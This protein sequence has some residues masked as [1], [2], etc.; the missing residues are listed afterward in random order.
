[1]AAALANNDV[2]SAAGRT[3]GNM[4]VVNLKATTNLTTVEQFR[5]MVITSKNGAIIRLK[6]VAT[7]ALGASGYDTS[8]SFNGLKAVYIGILVAP[9]ANLLNVIDDVRKILP[10][11]QSQLPEGLHAKIV[12]DST[13][14]VNSSIHEVISS[15]LEAF[16]IVAVVIFIFLGS[17]RSVSIPLV[18]IPLSLIGAF[19]IMYALHYSINLLTLLALVLAIG[20]VVDDA[21]IVVENVQ[22]HMEEGLSRFKAAMLGA[23]ELANPII[24]ITVVLIAVYVPIGFMGG[25]TGALFT[26]FAFT[27][28]GAVTISAV[29]ALTLS[30][31]MCS[32]LLKVPEANH[33]G[34][35]AYIDRQ[36]ERLRVMYQKKLHNS[37]EYLPVTGVFCINYSEQYLFSLCKFS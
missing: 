24:A 19:Y 3:D 5:Q 8:V 33:G 7:V 15:L 6:D 26:E 28:A 4:F 37:L 25:L 35:V 30:P 10:E 29:I 22:R 36:F 11:I 34:L 21:I 14:F 16:L 18:T 17:M 9:T 20:L 13:E 23:R 2:L 31:M 12:Y 27:L 32:K 1:M